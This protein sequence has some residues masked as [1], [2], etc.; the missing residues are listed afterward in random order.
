MNNLLNLFL[1]L[2][3][4]VET[5][6][7]TAVVAFHYVNPSGIVRYEAYVDSLTGNK[8]TVAASAKGPR[9]TLRGIRE[10]VEFYVVARA[11][12]AGHCES[13]IAVRSRTKLRGN[14][15]WCFIVVYFHSII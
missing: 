4:T 15:L 2:S 1:A 13:P 6:I 3:V 8:C 12:F 9:C 5:S 10:A 14:C 7:T 11:C